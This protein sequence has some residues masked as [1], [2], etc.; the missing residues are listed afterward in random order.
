MC[1]IIG[2]TSN[3]NVVNLLL[4]GLQKLEY[5]G[6]D[7]AGIAIYEN[8]KISVFK[9]L[10]QVAHLADIAKEQQLFS[11]VGIAHTRWATHGEVSLA[12][13]HPH[14]SENFAI[15]HNGII[16]NSEELKL[17]LIDA[18]CKLVSSTD[19][20][21]IVH[22]LELSYQATSD[23]LAAIAKVRSKLV[24]SYAL[25]IISNFDVGNIY[26]VRVG[27]PLVFGVGVDEMFISSDLLA[28]SRYV[29]EVCYLSEG[30]II[31]FNATDYA[32][33]DEHGTQVKRKLVI[34][35]QVADSVEKG[36][37][38]HYMLKEI[39]DQPQTLHDSIVDKFANEGLLTT[40]FELDDKLLRQVKSIYIVGCGTSYHAGLVAKYWIEAILKIPCSVEI[41]SEFLYRDVAI[42]DNCLYI[43]ISQ[44][45]ET[46]DVL[47]ALQKAQ[48]MN[49][50]STL[51]I[52]N[53]KNSSLVRMSNMHLLTMAG[54]E[55]GVA[56]TKAFTA[57]IT[58][59]L[60]LVHYLSV[61]NNLG[62]LL[63]SSKDWYNLISAIEVLL[64]EREQLKQ[65]ATN[66]L[67]K[68]S[69]LF[70]GRGILAPITAEGALKLK[71]ISYIH[72]ES[73]A[74]GELKHGPLAL[75][76]E[77]MPVVA[78]AS[79]DELLHKI[80]SNISEIASRK[81]KVYVF[82][83]SKNIQ[84]DEYLQVYS[85]PVVN[86]YLKPIL[87]AIPLQLLAYYVAELKGTDIDKPRNLA[88]S[89][90]VE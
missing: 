45:G 90:T 36:D 68:S 47:A 35:D 81:G 66:F 40:A 6:Y 10:D 69:C 25:A 11:K 57:Q 54:I 44:S 14:C 67:T 78:I 23:V 58:I 52:C 84:S 56:S 5:R 48:H 9:S 37:F 17:E 13:S 8:N 86:D 42:V 15:V 73:Y 20:E 60:L 41:A 12:N 59:L 1:G 29:D 30:D 31:K 70:I 21:V 26:A 34:A 72:A 19:T 33:Y 65:L 43:S 61:V 71:E 24:G 2:S 3:R 39:F 88:K 83:D 80:K 51:A 63:L 76:D 62:N 46:A 50:L 55:I 87:Y 75:I 64:S 77:N 28:I 74:A 18:G 22:L 4:S 38:K 82:T 32:I 27:S 7:S 85:L 89:V 79:A 53:V 16:E 49:F